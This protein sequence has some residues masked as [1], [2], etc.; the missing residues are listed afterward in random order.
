MRHQAINSDVID[1]LGYI[2]FLFIIVEEFK[3]PAL[4]PCR[5][6]I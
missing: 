1:K 3:K 6:E 2:A 4:S 5:E